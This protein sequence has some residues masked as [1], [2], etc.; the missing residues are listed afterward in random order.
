LNNNKEAILVID[1]EIA[2]REA[3]RMVLKDKYNVSAVSDAQEGLSFLSQNDI[4]LVVLDIMMPG[5]NG[6]E[7]L[8]KIKSTYPETEVIL[9]TAFASL[10]TARSAIRYGAF[11]Y[12]T[13]PFDKDEVIK[14]VERGLEKKRMNTNSVLEKEELRYK[15]K[16]LE[17]QINKARQNLFVSYEGTVRALILT[18]DAK[19]HYTYD[20]SE[21]V[22][23]LSAAI[24]NIVGLDRTQQIKLKQAALM[25]DIGKIGVDEFILRK[26]GAL[27]EE[28]FNEMKK[29]PAIGARIIQEIPFL[30]DALPVIKHHHEFYDGGGYPDGLKREEIP[31]TARMVGLADAID[32]MMRARP[33]R[34]AFEMDKVYREL[35]EN[36]GIQFDPELVDIVLKGKISLK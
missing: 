25:H 15:T 14:I 29:H 2:P 13:K 3:L 36:A 16:Y 33:Y 17:E 23:R 34:D 18:I 28:E 5:M 9:L 27:T 35:T 24:A 7:A 21:H 10:G 20:H 19:D 26:N 30:G 8:Q 4:D 6:I 32:S 11:D 1:D 12:M 31:L 22:A